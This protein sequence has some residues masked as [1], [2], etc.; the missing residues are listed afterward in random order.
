MQTITT[1]YK[2]ILVMDFVMMVDWYR[3]LH[4]VNILVVVSP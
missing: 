2:C 4:Q 3:L 1:L